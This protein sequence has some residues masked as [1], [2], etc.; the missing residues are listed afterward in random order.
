MNS[1]TTGLPDKATWEAGRDLAAAMFRKLRQEI[2]AGSCAMYA[3]GKL[4]YLVVDGV[5]TL[6][7]PDG[8]Q[9]NVCA[10]Y[11]R[12]LVENPALVIGFAAILT[13]VLFCIEE[14]AGVPDL[15]AH[16]RLT[17]EEWIEVPEDE[18][19]VRATAMDKMSASEFVWGENFSSSSTLI[20]LAGSLFSDAKSDY[21][22]VTLSIR[23]LAQFAETVAKQAESF[24]SL[25]IGGDG[26][27]EAYSSLL[28]L[29]SLVESVEIHDH[30]P[31]VY[32]GLQLLRI[33]EAQM[34]AKLPVQSAPAAP[35]AADQGDVAGS[36]EPELVAA[37]A[38]TI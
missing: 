19:G 5:K 17:Y 28:N 9:D 7:Y 13:G 31:A 8:V 20:E 10:P 29:I 36:Y 35:P 1:T 38:S 3:S 25:D 24:D 34:V 33:A 4:R 26:R 30:V 12:A 23:G 11:F 37:A 15:H 6:P 22:S 18:D 14:D 27:I 16:A 32:S 21:A 2:D